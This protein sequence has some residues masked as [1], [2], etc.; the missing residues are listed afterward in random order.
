MEGIPV[1]KIALLLALVLL[2]SFSAMAEGQDAE[3]FYLQAMEL[4]C[5]G[6]YENAIA[7]LTQAVEAGHAGAQ[8]NL[9]LCYH[10]G[11]GV[12]QNYE[13]AVKWYTLAAQQG[14]DEAQYH[15]GLCYLRGEGVEQSNEEAVK[16][17]T[18]AAQQGHADA[19]AALQR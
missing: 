4:L 16:W 5:S 7:P 13:E 17:F 1:K 2:F 3:A 19:A 9:G 18:L 10:Y 12:E 6:D 14:L 15:L 8:Y 11:D